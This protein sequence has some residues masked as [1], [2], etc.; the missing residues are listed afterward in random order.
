[1]SNIPVLSGLGNIASDYDAVI[2]DVW[3]VLHDGTRVYPAAAEALKNFHEKHG[4]VV[5]LS[6]APRPPADTARQLAGMGMPEGCYD[7]IVTSGGASRDDLTARSA[8]GTVK[9]LHIGPERDKPIYNGLDVVLTDAEQ[10]DV[11]LLTGLD[12]HDTETPDDYRDILSVALR[13]KLPALCANPD[14]LVP[15]GD[16]IVYCAGALAK[17]YAEM[18]GEVVYYGK[19]HL[20]VYKMALDA[21]KSHKKVLAIG[22]A[23]ETDLAGATNAGLDALFVTS[24]LHARDIGTLTPASVSAFL[25]DHDTTVCAAI[26]MLRW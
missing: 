21:A 22:D 14:I 23:L 1:M 18:G 25:A 8:K 20:P 5:L 15:I 12:D 3:G 16:R 7:A 11:L 26:D 13:H 24:G 10:A 2:C 6:N 17:L 9:L 19:P 4:K